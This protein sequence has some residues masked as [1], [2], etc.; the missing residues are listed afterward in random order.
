MNYKVSLWWD[1][2]GRSW[3][4]ESENFMGLALSHGS[5]DALMEQVKNALPDIIDDLTK[6]IIEFSMKRDVEVD[7]GE[8][9]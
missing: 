6:G 2:E 7:Y 8:L 9:V 5:L 1:S 4:A 3:I